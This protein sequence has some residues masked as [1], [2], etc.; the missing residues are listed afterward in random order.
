MPVAITVNTPGRPASLLAASLYCSTTSISEQSRQAEH[1][2]GRGSRGE[3]NASRFVKLRP[4][5]DG[6]CLSVCQSVCPL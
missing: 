6:V 2:T 1:S 4:P 5:V 3:V